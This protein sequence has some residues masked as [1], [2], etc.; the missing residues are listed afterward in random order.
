M[1]DGADEGSVGHDANDPDWRDSEG[2][3]R[4]RAADAEL[5]ALLARHDF[6]GPIYE[7]FELK[8]YDYGKPV[9]L[10]WLRTGE[11]FVQCR[12][13]NLRFSAP[14][15]PFTSDDRAQLA[16]YTLAA[17]LPVFRQLSLIEGGWTPGKAALTTYF[18]N[19]L[20]IHF[21]NVYRSWCRQ[22]RKEIDWRG[23]TKSEAD[24]ADIPDVTITSDPQQLYILREALQE[25]LKGLDAAT[26]S[27]LIMLNEGYE[28]AEISE[29]HGMSVRAIEAIVYRHRKRMQR[30]LGE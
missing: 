22:V 23:H 20:P 2:V 19:G 15:R 26:R 9:L 11:I 6:S 5:V 3:E 4:Q 29:I 21:S 7:K 30:R 27:I 25:E 17:A 10:A 14:P 16:N 18:V 12:R 24:L 28:Y 8:L 1:L 13:R